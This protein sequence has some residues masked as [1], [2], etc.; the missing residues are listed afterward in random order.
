MSYINTETLRLVVI[1]EMLQM[2]LP[3]AGLIKT[4]VF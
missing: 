2:I 4:P 3:M 1:V